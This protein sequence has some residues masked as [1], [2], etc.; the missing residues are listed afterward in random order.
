MKEFPGGTLSTSVY[1]QVEAGRDS[2]K[3]PAY[4]G[5]YGAGE[6]T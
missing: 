4:G 5:N 6:P 3:Y 2:P 1:R